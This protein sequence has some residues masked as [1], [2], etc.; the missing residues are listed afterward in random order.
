MPTIDS[1]KRHSLA[2]HDDRVG[3]M[4]HALE[5]S[6]AAL[7]VPRPTV[8]AYVTDTEWRDHLEQSLGRQATLSYI[9]DIRGRRT[10]HDTPDVAIFHLDP[11]TT[12]NID[13]QRTVVWLRQSYPQLPLL[14]YCRM[15]NGIAPLLVAAGRYGI[16]HALLR[17]Y[18]N[19]AHAVTRSVATRARS[20]AVNQVVA[21][22]EPMPERI[23]AI[24][25]HCTTR[26]FESVLTV[27]LLARELAVHRKTLFNQL[28]T[29]GFPG[30][31]ELITWC[32]LLLAAYV[33]DSGGGS[34]GE[35]TRSLHFASPSQ[36]RGML[37]RH[38]G[39]TPTAMR[40]FGALDTMIRLFPRGSGA[41]TTAVDRPD[42]AIGLPVCRGP[43]E[44]FLPTCT[45]EEG[46]CTPGD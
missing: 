6:A 18:D 15:T 8:L 39:L 19:I 21:R 43:V 38:T 14:A 41:S 34:V 37:S 13:V 1:S 26:A 27:E 30:P 35:M 42:V 31:A 36:Y 20:V 33:L 25:T 7:F 2:G 9:S 5:R 40:R 24:A 45:S 12:D 46:Y 23:R 17:G 29:V 10:R 22:L 28:R 16:D 11:R 44:L 3:S 32:R 4:S